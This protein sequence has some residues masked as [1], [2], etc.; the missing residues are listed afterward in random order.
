[1]IFANSF[2]CVLVSFG[3]LPG[4]LFA[5]KLETPNSKKEHNHKR[6]DSAETFNVLAT[7]IGHIPSAIARIAKALFSKGIFPSFRAAAIRFSKASF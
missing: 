6:I 5:F 7:C 1:M 3:G 2:F 4:D